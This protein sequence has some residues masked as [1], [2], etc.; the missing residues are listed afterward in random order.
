MGGGNP[1]TLGKAIHHQSNSL[2]AIPLQNVHHYAHKPQQA[3]NQSS[4]V[5]GTHL[6]WHP[7]PPPP[8][9]G[10]FSGLPLIPMVV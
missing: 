10:P 7:P 4:M 2:L 9:P 1:E 6:C 5:H 8:P 3:C